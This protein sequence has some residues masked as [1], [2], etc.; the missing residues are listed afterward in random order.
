MPSS[1]RIPEDLPGRPVKPDAAECC[2]RNCELCVFVYYE[3]A[4]ARWR[5]RLSA[6]GLSKL[7]IEALLQ[8]KDDQSD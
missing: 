7:E 8:D 4:L 6:A 5:S 3:K 2:G 1:R